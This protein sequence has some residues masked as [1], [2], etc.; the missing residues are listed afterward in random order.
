[1][2]FLFIYRFKQFGFETIFFSNTLPNKKIDKKCSESNLEK[3]KFV[4][5][6]KLK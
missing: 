4:L 2:G 5:K 6:N 3:K 1:M